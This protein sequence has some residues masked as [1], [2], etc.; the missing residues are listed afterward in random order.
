MQAV[1]TLVNSPETEVLGITVPTGDAWRDEEVAHVLRLLEIIGRTDIPVVRGAVFP[2]VNSKEFVEKWEAQYGHVTYQ[3]AWNTGNPVHDPWEIP[4]MPEGS[5]TTKAA[6]E[7]AASFLVR[8]VNEHP[9]E[10]TIYA[11]A[12][13]T[14]LALAIALDANFPEL[15]KELVVMGGSVNPKTDDPEFKAAPH[16]EFNFWMDPDAAHTVLQARWPRIVLTTVDISLTT[17]MDKML[18]EQIAKGTT[19]GAE[20]V[21]RYAQPDYLW[22]ELAAAAW[23]D[24]SMITKW[25]KLHVDVETNYDGSYGNTRT[26][27]P[28]KQPGVGGPLVEV[29]QTL[30]RDK[31][32]KLLVDL[33]TRPTPQAPSGRSEK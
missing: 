10:V 3:G 18:I 25:Q 13:L 23:L 7:D 11:A 27:T 24:P 31:F 26:W 5:P 6:T 4:A 8:M 20:Y 12:P 30:D 29:Q 32:Y 17:R 28:G 22:D 19:P 16:R 14:D 33:L 21:A 2:L 15:S 9:H 1:L